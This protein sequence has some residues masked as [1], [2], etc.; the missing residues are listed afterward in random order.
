MNETHNKYYDAGPHLQ[1]R[2]RRLTAVEEMDV[3]QQYH[4]A[5]PDLMHVVEF[6]PLS[7]EP[8]IPEPVVL[9]FGPLHAFESKKAPY[10]PLE[11]DDIFEH[12]RMLPRDKVYQN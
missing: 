12:I 8:V 3:Q 11:Q 5:R 7:Q 2:E 1:S 10:E 6:A 9:L 4:W